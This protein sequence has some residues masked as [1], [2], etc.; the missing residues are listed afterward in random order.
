[1]HVVIPV[2]L[3][4]GVV[5]GGGGGGDGNVDCPAVARHTNKITV[6]SNTEYSVVVVGGGWAEIINAH[7]PHIA[8]MVGEKRAVTNG[9]SPPK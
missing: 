2:C 1:M 5:L 3:W 6:Q 9:K 4:Y 8:D 7:Q